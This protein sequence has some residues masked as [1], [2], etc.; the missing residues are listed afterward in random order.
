MLVLHGLRAPPMYYYAV[1]PIAFI[2]AHMASSWLYGISDTAFVV[3]ETIVYGISGVIT[4][5]SLTTF[6]P[7]R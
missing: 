2:A 1:F 5:W 6:L 4:A 7:R 3:L